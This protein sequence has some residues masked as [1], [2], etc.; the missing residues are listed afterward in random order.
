MKLTGQ[1]AL[2]TGGSKGIG[3]AT[4]LALAREGAN[5]VFAARDEG[6]IGETM[7]ELKEMSG[8]ALAIRADVR[9]E[10]D[11]KRLISKA[12]DEFG[13]LDILV[14]NAGVAYRKPLVE[15][16][17]EEYDKIMD[18]NLKGIFLCTKYAIPYIRN[19]KNGKIVN[20]SSGAGLHGIPE[21]SIYCAS[22]SGVISITQSIASELEGEIKVYAI[23]PGGVDTDMYRT[24]FGHKPQLKPE[25]IARKVLELVSPDSNVASGKIIE[26][27]SPPIPHF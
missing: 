16:T 12:V 19:S 15:T 22:K 10:E 2:I 8:R 14:N 21:L 17:L 20:I 23:C 1:T 9:Y 7:E 6:R 26:V 5:I 11:V 4:C 18:T 25:H 3:R 27:Y 13:G 24:L